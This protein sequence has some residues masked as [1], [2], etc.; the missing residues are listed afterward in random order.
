MYV[1][2]HQMHNVLNH[3]SKQLSQNRNAN[4]RQA[5]IRKP[6][7]DQINVALDGKRQATMEKVSNE[8]YN[9]ITGGGSLSNQNRQIDSQANEK[10]PYEN[11]SEKRS[12]NEFVFNVIDHIN[13]KQTNSLPV[14]DSSLLVKKLEKMAK[15]AVN[16]RSGIMDLRM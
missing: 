8:I 5:E 3:Y 11:S 1:P 10:P 4:H 12:D 14:E 15:E 7:A 13:Q 9:K 2:S 6:A 16:K